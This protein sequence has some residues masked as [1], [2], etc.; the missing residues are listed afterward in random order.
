M[1]KNKFSYSVYRITLVFLFVMLFTTPVMAFDFDNVKIYNS[2]LKEIT[3][4]DSFLGIP[5]TTVARVRLLT[6]QNYNVP[7]G[8][9]IKVA[10]FELE[11]YEDSYENALKSMEFYN[12]RDN[13]KEFS[14]QFTYKIKS[15]GTETIDRYETQC[16]PDGFH[17]NGTAKQVCQDVIVGQEIKVIDVW[18]PIEGTDIIKGE[19]VIGIFVDILQEEKVE[20]IPTLFG[21]EIEEWATWTAGLDVGLLYYWNFDEVGGGSVAIDQM[22][23][24]NLTLNNDTFFRN[25]TAGACKNVNC[26]YATNPSHNATLEGMV[27]LDR[28]TTDGF[29]ISFWVKPVNPGAYNGIMWNADNGG[30]P[31]SDGE[32]GILYGGDTQTIEPRI[33]NTNGRDTGDNIQAMNWTHFVVKMTSG[34]PVQVW[35]NGTNNWNSSSGFTFTTFINQP[36]KIFGDGTP[37]G[38][39]SGT[40]NTAID[41]LAIWNRSLST[42]EVTTLFDSGTGTFR[43]SESIQVSLNSPP[44][45][46]NTSSTSIQFNASL[47]PD[48]ISINNATLYLYNASGTQLSTTI[49]NTIAS[50]SQINATWTLTGLTDRSYLWNVYGCGNSSSTTYCTTA[51]SN[52]SFTIDSTAPSVSITYPTARV[53]YHQSGRNITINWTASDSLSGLQTCLVDYNGANRSVTCADNTTQYNITSDQNRTAVFFAN[54]SIG[55]SAIATQSWNYDVF[56]W[57][58]TFEASVFEFATHTISINAS[59]NRTYYTN[60]NTQLY[61]NNS[62]YSTTASG[63][64]NNE[65]YSTSLSAPPTA[66][67]STVNFL[68][69][70]NLVNSSTTLQANTS[71]SSQTISNITIDLCQ[72]NNTLLMNLTLFDENNKTRLIPPTTNGTIEIDLTLFAHANP[73]QHQ[74]F[75]T[76]QSN[77]NPVQICISN[78]TINSSSFGLGS[79]IR[80][81]ADERVVEFYHLQN[82]TINLSTTPFNIGL[83]DLQTIDSQSFLINYKDKNFLPVKD[84]LIEIHRKYIPENA[85]TIVE[86]PK[87]DNQGQTVAHLLLEDVFYNIFVKKNNRLLASFSD[88]IAICQNPTLN[89]CTLNLNEEASTISPEDFI[90]AGDINYN[91]NFNNTARTVTL[92]YSTVDGSTKTVLLN[93]SKYDVLG[94]TTICQSSLTSP[95]GTI[96]CNIAATYGNTTIR[97]E[98]WSAGEFIGYKI[99]SLNVL[100]REIFRTSGIIFTIILILVLVFMFITSPI[101]M[102][103]AFVFGLFIAGAFNLITGVTLFSLGSS[104]MWLIVSSA[105]LI[106]QINKERAG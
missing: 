17:L 19:F 83:Y 42:A 24:R 99:N 38:W 12:L 29:T 35:V 89:Q 14:R 94:N 64:G 25:S 80:Y 26:I 9:E 6:P 76:N 58:R 27:A 18:T 48:S 46:F 30:Q 11:L 2:E 50:I 36:F 23:R 53:N 95:S 79:Q 71:Q 54:D 105:I 66:A 62:I 49:N 44:S 84:V 85:F 102:I 86:I 15:Q 60:L 106:Y 37:N 1:I 70:F 55:N 88:V 78:N 82:Q 96:I 22:Q 39:G 67:Q 28:N 75:S 4:K 91:L 93:V 8:K 68:W 40:P 98:V 21:V 47:L 90:Q 69:L 10:E 7:L 52:R 72:T 43:S 101:G 45:A 16:S 31:F 34:N 51:T 20:W 77:K 103:F 63:S 41:E 74:N 56:E 5:T 3:I 13:N 100:S 57:N 59:V 81:F 104:L 97:S 73:S 32:F 87:T 61:Y 92:I 65:L 33:G